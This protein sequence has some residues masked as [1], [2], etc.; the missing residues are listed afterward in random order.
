MNFARKIVDSEKLI[1]IIDLP[2]DLKRKQVE[3]IVLPPQETKKQKAKKK[4]K[5][6]FIEEL[7]KN[8]IKMDNF[9][10]LSRKEIYE[11]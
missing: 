5:K 8:P 10:P 3:I 7:I 9:T 6:N 2:E 4:N 11:R 1:G